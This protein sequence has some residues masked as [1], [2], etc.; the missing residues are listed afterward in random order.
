MMTDFDSMN[1]F[2]PHMNDTRDSDRPMSRL[3]DI[4][5]T[6]EESLL[7]AIEICNAASWYDLYHE[8]KSCIDDKDYE[9]AE[10]EREHF[11]KY[12]DL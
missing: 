5:I 4:T 11:C 8:L 10:W 2:N 6:D 12:N 3:M 9:Y 1:Q 7:R